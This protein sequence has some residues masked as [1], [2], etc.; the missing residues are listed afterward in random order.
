ME[1]FDLIAVGSGSVMTVVQAFLSLNP[2]GRVAVID[3]EPPGGICLRKGCI[4]TK[5]LVYPAELL[6]LIQGAPALGID[7]QIRGVDFPGIMA[8]MRAAVA[9]DVASLR[10]GFRRAANPC[11]TQPRSGPGDRS[12]LFRAFRNRSRAGG[13]AACKS[14]F[15]TTISTRR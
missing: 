2:R 12:R 5:L 6:R 15:G 4:P 8:R 1:T 14:S 10:E 11:Y 7:V 9:R 3:Q 13:C